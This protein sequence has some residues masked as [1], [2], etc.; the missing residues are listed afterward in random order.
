M[1]YIDPGS[2]TVYT[3]YRQCTLYTADY[4]LW[5]EKQSTAKDNDSS[6]NFALH[7]GLWRFVATH[8]DCLNNFR[9][10]T[11][12][13]DKLCTFSSTLLLPTIPNT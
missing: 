6:S 4:S 9:H 13:I 11:Q 12:Q 10:V 8:E 2:Y 5:H 7:N 1:I 3:S